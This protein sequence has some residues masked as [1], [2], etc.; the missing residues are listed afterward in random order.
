M[1]KCRK[2]Q[3]ALGLLIMLTLLSACRV[4]ADRYELTNYMGKSIA[5]FEKRSGAK[6]VEQGT[7][8]YAQE[9]VMQVMAPNKEVN[10]ITLLEGSKEYLLFGVHVGMSRTDAQALLSDAFGKEITKTINSDNND[11]TYTYLKNNQQLYISYDV[12]QE[13]VTEISYY[14]VGSSKEED[15]QTK[16]LN[17]GELMAMIGNEKVYYN[18]AMVYLKSA[19]ENYET[20]YGKNIWNADILGNGVTFGNMIK[21]EVM[22][23]ITEIKII[24]AQAQE[25]GITLSEEEIADANAYAKEHYEGLRAEDIDKYLITEELLKKVYENNLLAEKAFETLTIN[26]NTD[27]PD[28]E[29]KQITVQQ[30][31]IYS[32]EFDTD[33]REQELSAQEKSEAYEK[34]KD[35]LEQAKTTDDFYALA[36]ANSESDTI[37]YTF[38]RGEGPEDY[39]SSFEQAAFTLKTGQVS[40]IISTDYGWHI[41]YCV[42]DD[43]KDA[44]TQKKEEIIEK[45]RSELFAKLYEEWSA[46]FDV[47]VNSEAWNTVSFEE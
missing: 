35:L 19:Q 10:A 33:G 8:I 4:S 7:G 2:L 12:D 6:L 26:V 34:V 5:T 37:E 1:K 17:S 30:I 25:Q 29:A 32:V 24:C 46:N 15:T 43:N 38:G 45:R 36:E 9:Q 14:L 3:A 18:E 13:T 41:L 42:S 16:Q 21:D 47:I 40:N 31:L 11:V 39:S 28:Y 22:N 27:V 20:D 23:Q 44:T